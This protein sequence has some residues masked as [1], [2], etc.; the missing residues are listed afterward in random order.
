MAFCGARWPSCPLLGPQTPTLC[1][2][3]EVKGPGVV[4]MARMRPQ[5]PT[6]SLSHLHLCPSQGFLLAMSRKILSP[7]PK[8]GRQER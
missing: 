8:S 7:L 1:V 5:G 6:S 3:G 4:A 2:L